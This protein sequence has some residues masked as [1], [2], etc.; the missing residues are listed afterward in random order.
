MGCQESKRSEKSTPSYFIRALGCLCD[1]G[2]T[3]YDCSQLL[4]NFGDD[5]DTLDQ[6]DEVQSIRCQDA[7]LSGNI[8]F[9]FRQQSSISLSPLATSEDVQA[10]L[11]TVLSIGLVRVTP[12]AGSVDTICAS[13]DINVFNVQFLTTHG[14]LPLIRVSSTAIDDITIERTTEGN[15]ENL[16]C[17]G[18]GICSR[19]TG[20]CQCFT[21][22]ASSDGMGKSGTIDDCGYSTMNTP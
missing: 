9:S 4:C 20:I 11:S 2:Y 22:Y 13:S 3:G 14:A 16:E 5:P 12:A 21:G 17:S 6:V 7:D 8:V 1:S 10:A 15:K 18:R 19:A